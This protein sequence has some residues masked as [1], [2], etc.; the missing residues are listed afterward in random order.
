MPRY[1]SD[2]M[3]QMCSGPRSPKYDFSVLRLAPASLIEPPLQRH[4]T[5]VQWR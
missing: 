5:V 4:W 2:Y 3:V 1:D